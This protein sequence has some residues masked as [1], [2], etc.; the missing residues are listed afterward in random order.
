MLDLNDIMIFARVIE[1]GSFTAAARLLG[2]PKTTVS[3]R[4]ATLERELGVRLLQRTT[5]SLNLTDAGRLYYEE[6]SQALRTIEGAN[7]RLA[8]AR[9][10]PA[11][12]IRISAPVGFG[13]P[14]LQ[15]AIF[16]F[17]STYPKTRV[18]LRLTDDR[19]N[20]VEN[21]I[22]LA[23]RTGILEDSTLIAR[24]LG[25]THRILCASPEY[26][27]RCGT[28]D[29]PADLTRHDCVIAGQSAHTPWLLEGPHGRETVSVSGRF[30][31]NE[32]QA[33]MAA[34][35]AGYGIAQLPYRVGQ[36]CIKDGRLCRVL[37]GYATPVG[38]LYVVYPSSRHLPPL[39]K[40]FIELAASRLDAG[41]DG[42]D[43]FVIV[44]P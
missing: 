19:L 29:H 23:F 17:L 39:V 25:S 7:L 10:E 12:T 43:E 31:A 1:A 6:S 22:D 8:E 36:T 34:A 26:I 15:E 44:S 3:R 30:A 32:M 40:S 4:I 27:A 35:I 21:G 33:V 37:D 9:A 24:K 14:F 20:L 41:T 5:R 2:M 16:D 38:G 18:E 28:P 13:G 11:G 42:N